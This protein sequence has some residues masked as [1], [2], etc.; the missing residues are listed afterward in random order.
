[1]ETA[2]H[3][4]LRLLGVEVTAALNGLSALKCKGWL[5]QLLLMETGVSR[6]DSRAYFFRG[7]RLHHQEIL[8]VALRSLVH[9]YLI[10]NR[11]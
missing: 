9:I 3:K 1:M 5:F 10:N 11:T 8:H 7:A 2:R 6:V 4:L